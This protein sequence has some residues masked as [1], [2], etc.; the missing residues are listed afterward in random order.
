MYVLN[1]LFDVPSGNR[2]SL[3]PIRLVPVGVSNTQL[4]GGQVAAT[5][6]LSSKHPPAVTAVTLH[7]L[8]YEFGDT[9]NGAKTKDRAATK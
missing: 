9:A 6:Q 8:W 7:E 2:V 3:E 1:T 4:L 5:P